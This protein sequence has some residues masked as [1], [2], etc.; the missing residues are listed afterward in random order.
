MNKVILIGRLVRDPNAHETWTT[1]TIAVD[2]RFKK[3]NEPDADFFDCV[4]FG[5]TA[6]FV[7]DYLH[8]GTKIAL[9]GRL[10]TRKYAGV[11]GQMKY[12]TNVIAENIEFAESKRTETQAEVEWHDADDT[13]LPFN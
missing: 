12:T 4:C 10:Q 11:D 2:R 6:G 8:K 5:K 3:D 9:E 1:F 13:G 7:N